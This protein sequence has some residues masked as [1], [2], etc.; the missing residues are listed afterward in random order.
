MA[1]SQPRSIFGVHSITPY[2]RTTGIPYGEARVIK[3]STFTLE[4][5]TVE[6][7]GGSNRAAWSVEDGDISAELA[8]SVSEYPNWLFELFGGKAPTPGSAEPAGGVS[9]LTDK[10]GTTVVGA[11]GL[12]GTITVSTAANLKFGRYVV[13]ATGAGALTVYALSDVDFG[14]GSS[15]D[16]LS[17]DLSVATFTG[18]GTGSTHAISALGITFTAGAS[19]G[20]MTSGDTATFEIRPINTFNREVI[21]GG[22]SDTFPEFGCLVYAQKSGSGAVVEIEAYKCKAIGLSL[23]AERKTFGESDYTAKL[24]YD[25]TA[26]GLCRIREIE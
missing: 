3:G 12:L 7:R 2:S 10:N 13:K 16:F 24:A 14:R 23:G 17:D 5:D 6:L 11:T 20:A 8:F 22:V 9:T 25:S 21:I 26:N 19:A 18:V 1:L 15:L 4:G